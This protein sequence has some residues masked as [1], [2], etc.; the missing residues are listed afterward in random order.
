MHTST[1]CV[2]KMQNDRSYL[3]CSISHGIWCYNLEPKFKGDTYKL[4]IQNRAT[5]VIYKDYKRRENGRITKM[6]E[7]T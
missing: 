1:T 3:L 5:G 7:R 4:K 6:R 2:K